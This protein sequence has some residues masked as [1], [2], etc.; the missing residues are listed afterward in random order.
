MK[1][2][3]LIDYFDLSELLS[4]AKTACL[5][6]N[7]KAGYIYF[8][9]HSLREKLGAFIADDNGFNTCKHTAREL[10]SE[11]DVWT[12]ANVMGGGSPPE[13]DVDKFDGELRRWTYD[14][15]ATKVD[16]FRNVFTAECQEVEV[17]SVGQISIYRTNSLVSKGS[18]R[19]PP[20]YRDII[21]P[22]ALEEFDNA[23][24]CLAF[25][26]PTACGF[27]SLRSVELTILSYLKAF[28]ADTKSLKTWHDYVKAVE[29]MNVNGRK[30]S[31]KVARMLDRMRDLDRNPLMHPRDTLDATQ[32]DMLFSLSAI[33]TGEMARDMK[34]REEE[35]RQK[36]GTNA[37]ARAVARQR[38]PKMD[39]AEKQDG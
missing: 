8:A 21:P 26:L 16:H 19:I 2:V 15:I 29:T 32:A 17:Y 11:I 18:H 37:L 1:R 39:D 12:N 28:G 33:T 31:E 9:T 10:A 22:E 7:A 23:G 24:R 30:A 38:P 25:D 14:G 27:H 5:R 35:E 36:A 4:R 3:N 13:L 6:D 34:L 20:Q